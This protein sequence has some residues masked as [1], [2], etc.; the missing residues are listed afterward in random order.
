MGCLGWVSDLI[1]KDGV[2]WGHVL[3]IGGWLP[4]T[5][6]AFAWVSCPVAT[7]PT[8]PLYTCGRFWRWEKFLVQGVVESKT[9]FTSKQCIT[10]KTEFPANPVRSMVCCLAVACQMVVPE[11]LWR[12]VADP[13]PVCCLGGD[14]ESRNITFTV[15]DQKGCHGDGNLP[16]A[17]KPPLSSGWS[18]IFAQVVLLAKKGQVKTNLF[19]LNG[20]FMC[21][22]EY[23]SFPKPFT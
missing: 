4:S 19:F 14:V 15:W 11:W 18:P 10:Q 7:P 5:W 21:P 3:L 13:N 2:E 9:Y 23:D 1:Q 6:V 17:I 22:R 8:Y 20:A 12:C 16:G